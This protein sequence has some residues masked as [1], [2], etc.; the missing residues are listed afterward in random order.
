MES[1]EDA[2]VRLFESGGM[3]NDPG[4]S[5]DY[6]ANQYE[7]KQ[8]EKVKALL[9]AKSDISEVYSPPR[10]AKLAS[11][12][13]MQGGF[14]LDLTNPDELGYVWDFSKQECRQRARRKQKEEKETERAEEGDTVKTP[15]PICFFD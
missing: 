14:S 15:M 13:G 12:L 11:E 8:M 3:A 7:M 2:K 1:Q 6:F 4:P 5:I 10:I 9:G